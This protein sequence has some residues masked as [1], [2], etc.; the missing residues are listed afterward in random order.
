MGLAGILVILQLSL[1]SCA[2]G[3]VNTVESGDKLTQNG[4]VLIATQ[5]SEFKQAVVQAIKE[6]LETHWRYLKVIDVRQLP[7][8]ITENYQA[9]IILSE[10]LAG[11]P[12]PRVESFI[13]DTVEKEKL[14]VL[15]TGRLGSWKPE[16]PGVDAMTSA[17]VLTQADTIGQLIAQ[18]T[19][20]LINSR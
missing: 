15:T 17:S 3:T 5:K 10:C 14:I 9:V 18:K 11:R 2:V 12:D 13:D 6:R 19:L 16:S 20:K 7:D 1:L 4:R 8:E